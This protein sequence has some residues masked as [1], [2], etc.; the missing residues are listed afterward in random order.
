MKTTKYAKRGRPKSNDPVISHGIGMRQKYWD[1]INE[2]G[3]GVSLSDKLQN[4]MDTLMAYAPI[5]PYNGRERD[6]KGRWKS[7]KVKPMRVIEP[8]GVVNT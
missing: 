1:Y 5:G 6:S 7:S 4:M 2:Y 3:D 8:V